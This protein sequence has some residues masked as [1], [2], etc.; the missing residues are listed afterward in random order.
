MIFTI[1]VELDYALAKRLSIYDPHNWNYKD[2]DELLDAIC[3]AVDEA[4]AE[5]E[6]VNDGHN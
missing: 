1:S 2:K 6:E 4:T 3:K 5:H